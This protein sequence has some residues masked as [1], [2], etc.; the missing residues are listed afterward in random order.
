MT[1]ICNFADEITFHVCGKNLNTLIIRLEQDTV[2]ADE[3]FEKKIM[4]L[5]QDKCHLLFSG[6]KP[7]TLWA[8]IIERKISE[9]NK[10]ELLG[11]AI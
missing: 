6:H 7:E 5:N 11:V 1:Q 4:K 8:K 3:W 2:L 9:N 10:Q